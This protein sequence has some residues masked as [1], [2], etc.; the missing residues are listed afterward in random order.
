MHYNGRLT[1]TRVR[2]L[3]YK[4]TYIIIK[5]ELMLLERSEHVVNRIVKAI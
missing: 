3:I 2:Y 5:S 1:T 4:N